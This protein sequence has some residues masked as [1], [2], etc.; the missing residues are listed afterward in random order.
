M[1]WVLR[2]N[3][4]F[5]IF[6][7]KHSLKVFNLYNH[8]SIQLAIMIKYTIACWLQTIHRFSLKLIEKWG[9]QK[10]YLLKASTL[11]I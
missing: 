8:L 6:L 3:R 7:K 9:T 10:I 2:Q 11:T 1:P 4:V 5:A